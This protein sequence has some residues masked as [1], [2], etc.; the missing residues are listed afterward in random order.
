MAEKARPITRQTEAADCPSI[1]VPKQLPLWK[2]LW[3]AA[4]V[5]EAAKPLLTE[6]GLLGDQRLP[7]SRPA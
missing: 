2:S 3:Y 6:P 4:K 1:A 5:I 7:V